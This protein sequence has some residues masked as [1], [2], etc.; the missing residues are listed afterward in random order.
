MAAGLDPDVRSVASVFVSRWDVAVAATVPADLRNQLGN[1]VA[2]STYA[3]SRALHGS[4]RWLRAQN[5]G[6]RP[7]RVLWA[8]TGTKDPSAPDTLYVEALA[9]PYTVDTV[10]EAT[11]LAFAD[12]GRVGAPIPADGGDA[13]EVIA[14]HVRHGVDMEALAARL[15]EE[16]AKAFVKS[17]N[18][19]LDGI[20]R[21]TAA[22]GKA[23]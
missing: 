21:K 1:A 12:H 7:Q 11:L 9:A 13:G 6:A 8:S 23:P 17:W 14:R 15:Q 4:P 3:A 22:A 19:L 18:D 2:R 10:P 16:G 20:A 5:A